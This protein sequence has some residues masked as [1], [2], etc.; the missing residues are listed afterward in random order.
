MKK[1]LLAFAASLAFIASAQAYTITVSDFSGSGAT[2]SEN[3]IMTSQGVKLPTGSGRVRLGFFPTLTPTQVGTLFSNTDKDTVFSNITTNFVP[4]GEGLD[5]DLGGPGGTGG[6]APPR[7][8]TR[9]VNGVTGVTGRLAGSVVNVVPVA[10][11]FNPAN[12]TGVQGG[13]RLYMLV[14]DGVDKSTTNQVGIFSADT[15]LAPSDNLVNPTL[16]TVD[17]GPSEIFLG[18]VG[19]LRLAPLTV[20]PEPSTSLM[21][22]LAGMGLIARRRR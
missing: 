7:F 6:G 18:S 14:Y 13:T 12:I 4:L 1:T 22:L 5:A 21:A 2:F 16:N 20:I 19:S 9:T 15:W 11:A 3:V 10:T 17:V 8:A